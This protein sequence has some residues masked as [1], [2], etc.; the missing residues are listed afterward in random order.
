MQDNLRKWFKAMTEGVSS[1]FIYK[2][3][4][5]DFKLAINQELEITVNVPKMKKNL[6][7]SNQEQK[8]E[9]RG[10]KFMS[11]LMKTKTT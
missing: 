8:M 6:Q 2:Y 7:E 11:D 1:L 9:T 5:P 10:F 3:Y 4:D